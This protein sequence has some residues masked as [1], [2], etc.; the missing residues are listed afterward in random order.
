MFDNNWNWF[1]EVIETLFLLL[2]GTYLRTNKTGDSLESESKSDSDGDAG[3][4]IILQ[5]FSL[6][7]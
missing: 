1:L 3:T 7:G 4:G 6:F 5:V 2:G